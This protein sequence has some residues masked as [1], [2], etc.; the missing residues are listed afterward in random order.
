MLLFFFRSEIGLRRP[1]VRRRIVINTPEDEVVVVPSQAAAP[2]L[3]IMP[4][5][6][7][8]SP[9]SGGG[10]THAQLPMLLVLVKLALGPSPRLL[11]YA[12]GHRC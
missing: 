5:S 12:C 2:M 1:A 6:P 3:V 10:G 7:V 8:S 9:S 4:P 11:P